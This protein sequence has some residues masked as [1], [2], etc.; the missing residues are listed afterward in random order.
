[1][2]NLANGKW[3]VRLEKMSVTELKEIGQIICEHIELP[4]RHLQS[5]YT[6]YLKILANYHPYKRDRL[7]STHIY[8]TNFRILNAI[9]LISRFAVQV[10]SLGSN[11]IVTSHDSFPIPLFTTDFDPILDVDIIHPIRITSFNAHPLYAH[12]NS[13]RKCRLTAAT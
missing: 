5:A 9:D 1:M 2:E 11:A 4:H 13:L 12:L 6:F 10:L 8:K 3:S 7:L